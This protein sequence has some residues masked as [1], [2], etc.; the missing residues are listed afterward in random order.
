MQR[1]RRDYA[2]GLKRLRFELAQQIRENEGQGRDTARLQAQLDQL[3]VTRQTLDA[4]FGL[5]PSGAA[6]ALEELTEACSLFLADYAPVEGG[7]DGDAVV[8]LTVHLRTIGEQVHASGPLPVLAG[9][10]LELLAQHRIEAASAGPGH[11]FAVPLRGAGYT[12][13]KHLYILGMDEGLLS[14]QRD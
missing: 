6:I 13:R 3:D 9:T 4:L 2:D 7:Y 8:S 14:R 5:L 1:G 12:H 11:A 10:L